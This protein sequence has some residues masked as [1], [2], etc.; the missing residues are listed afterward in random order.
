[1][2]MRGILPLFALAIPTLILAAGP[3]QWRE[4]SIY[5]L[6]TDRFALPDGNTTS[7][8]D[9]S[10]ATYCGGTWSGIERQLD[11]IQDMGFDAIWISP[12]TKNIEQSTEYGEAYHGYW[13]QDIYAVNPRFGTAGDLKAL[14]EALHLRG[15]YLMVD[16]VVNHNAWPGPPEAVDFSALNPF[17]RPSDYHLP[18]CAVDYSDLTDNKRVTDCWMGDRVVSL[19]DLKTGD[20]R[21]QDEY[22][23]WISELVSNYSIDGLRLDTVLQVEKSF[24]R[25]FTK[26]AAGIYMV[27][28]AFS[29][30][31]RIVCDYENYLPGAM[32]YPLEVGAVVAK[33]ER[34]ADL[35]SSTARYFPLVNAFSK[36]TNDISELARSIEDMSRT[37][38]DTSL[39]GSFSE[40]HDNP[41][42]PSKNGDIAL[43][44]NVITFTMLT[45]GIP[46]IYQ[47]QEQHYR[48]LG[49]EDNPYNREALWLSGYDQNHE[50]Y[51]L[52]TL[53]NR[54]RKHAMRE[55]STFLT[56]RAKVVHKSVQT[57]AIE[58]GGLLLVLS[59][60]GSQSAKY[61]RS[62][63]SRF[64]VGARL[65]DIL[66]CQTQMVGR[67]GSLDVT[68]EAGQ[69]RVYYSS[70][71]KEGL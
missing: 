41:R 20:Q 30:D 31:S 18:Y 25:E 49:G 47:G 11:Y 9:T 46:I 56:T 70:T 2:H 22:G 28:E 8:C 58:K 62:I 12:V 5:Q 45:D 1:M 10:K 27:G 61:N 21:V 19:P 37:C 54:V 13:Q 7:A 4:R 59:N 35:G 68:L 63:Q 51:K 3:A 32:N 26:A 39:L 14:A 55:D 44:K 16:I 67:N 38:A 60:G 71:G 23:R 29:P 57:I 69:P 66:T 50:L 17:N 24:W 43:A 6:L 48:S 33:S 64:P 65:T 36:P 40:N 15:M 42:F 52:I 53:L 34:N